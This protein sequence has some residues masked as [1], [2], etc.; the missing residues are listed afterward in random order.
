LPYI[1]RYI[2]HCFKALETTYRI[3]TK[4]SRGP[5]YPAIKMYVYI[6]L[7]RLKAGMSPN[8]ALSDV[9]I[10]TIIA[11]MCL[12]PKE[13]NDTFPQIVITMPDPNIIPFTIRVP[14]TSSDSWVA[15]IAISANGQSFSGIIVTG[16]RGV[17]RGLDR[18]DN[19][20]KHSI[21]PCPPTEWLTICVGDVPII[22]TTGKTL[23]SPKQLERIPCTPENEVLVRFL[24]GVEGSRLELY[25]KVP[26]FSPI[27]GVDPQKFGPEYYTD[28]ILDQAIQDIIMSRCS[29][30]VGFLWVPRPY[31]ELERK[32]YAFLISIGSATKLVL[33]CPVMLRTAQ[34][35]LREISRVILG[36]PETDVTTLITSPYIRRAVPIHLLPTGGG[37]GGGAPSGPVTIIHG[38]PHIT[39]VL[40]SACPCH[41]R[42]LL[43]FLLC[44]Q[45]FDRLDNVTPAPRVL[46]PLV[47]DPL[48]LDP[49]VLDQLVLDSGILATDTGKMVRAI[50]LG[51]T[52]TRICLPGLPREI[53]EHII[54]F[55]VTTTPSCDCVV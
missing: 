47:L 3:S 37:G 22:I 46:D 30:Y 49:L 48:V 54:T 4:M 17:C 40:E 5:N 26:L 13:I 55:Y 33:V 9:I 11:N 10:R 1:S 42:R 34:Q 36:Q 32:L 29:R 7:Q 21:R 15:M 27:S 19:L 52:Q 16:P 45:R 35:N 12:S 41:K 50:I 14:R 20:S 51:I 18:F 6:M 38:P 2:S 24:A 25:C 53:I 23:F 44:M 39:R 8:H 31:S 28:I 43:S